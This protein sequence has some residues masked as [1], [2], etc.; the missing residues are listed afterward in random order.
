MATTTISTKLRPLRLGFL[1]QQD[2]VA[3]VSKAANVACLLWGGIRNPIIPIARAEDTNADQLLDLFNVDVL[4]PVTHSEPIAQFLER[5]AY[6]QT[7][8]SYGH[9]L[10]VEDWAT[11]KNTLAYLDSL[12]IIERN[13]Q[14]EF[15][16]LPPKAKSNCV[17]ATWDQDDP[18][19][20][21]FSIAFG[22]YSDEHNLLHNFADAFRNDLR[23]NVIHIAKRDAVPANWVTQI[24]P[25]S[26]T[27]FHLRAYGASRRDPGGVYIGDSADF[28]DLVCFWNLR[29]AGSSIVF[30]PIAHTGRVEP[31]ARAH[32]EMLDAQPHAHPNIEDWITFSYRQNE[33]RSR[34]L[35]N[36]FETKKRKA[37]A[38]CDDVIWNGLNVSPNRFY[39]G[40]E[41]SLAQIDFEHGRHKVTVMLPEKKFLDE[42]DRNTD[43]Q[44]LAVTLS[45]LGEFGY[46]GHT[47]NPPF[48]RDHNEFYSRQMAF[49]S[50]RIRSEPEGIGVLITARE[51]SASVRPIAKKSVIQAI[52]ELTGAKVET[53][54]PGRLAD[55]LLEKIGGVDGARVFK[56]RG[57]RKLI[58]NLTPQRTTSRGEA[59]RIIWNERQFAQHE[60]LY[61]EQRETP[62]LG[63]DDVF[64]SLLRHEFFRAG[65]ELQCVQCRLIGWHALRQIDDI[66]ICEFCGHRNLTSLHIRNRGDWRFRKS[67]LL[68]KDNNQEGSIPVILSL[69]VFYRVFDMN[70]FLYSTS[71]NVHADESSC[72]VDFVGLEFGRSSGTQCVIGEAK[73]EG[74][75]IDDIDIGNMR[76]IRGHM[77]NIG[78]NTYLCFAKTAG[79]FRPDEIR[80]FK[81]LRSDNVPIILLTNQEIEPY[82]PYAPFGSEG[83]A[84]KVPHEHAV[85][86]REMAENSDVRYLGEAN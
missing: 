68:A 79:S 12:H 7:P 80:Q 78:I 53:S 73:G 82:F 83:S 67:G 10:L 60:A 51:K 19:S 59:T 23:S 43:D 34:E 14:R 33:E 15:K 66:W 17:Y 71:L 5:H 64:D 81:K 31:Y 35:V 40:W 4:Y 45:P 39:F 2:S 30:L 38:H 20:H 9:Q 36:R 50:R 57:V 69:L 21:L 28:A 32:V 8:H 52:L 49:D 41:N 72:E 54:Q 22:N 84:S 58:D 16:T 65:L 13:W 56:I 46:P 25:L 62:K 11:K 48:R 47:L 18:L 55:R 6:L 42:S 3:D 70:G 44:Y 24:N 85:T 75:S 29:A 37:L 1:V 86:L 77:Q 74:G 26:L 63:T 61:I 76:R 27:G